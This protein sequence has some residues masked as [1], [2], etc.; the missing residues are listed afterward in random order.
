GRSRLWRDAASCPPQERHSGTL[1]GIGL[2][3]QP[4]QVD[5][6]GA[7][8]PRWAGPEFDPSTSASRE[9]TGVCYP[10]V[11]IL[12]SKGRVAAQARWYYIPPHV[13]IGE[14]EHEA[15]NFDSV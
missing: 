3:P 12:K 7:D 6:R 5:V 8:F 14:A 10:R 9:R 2:M 13:S 11:G 15:R 4:S 1:A